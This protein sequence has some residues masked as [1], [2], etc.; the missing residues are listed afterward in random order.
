MAF[1]IAILAD[2]SREDG[3]ANGHLLPS[4]NICNHVR[5]VMLKNY[6]LCVPFP[7]ADAGWQF[8]GKEKA[9]NS[10]IWCYL[11]VSGEKVSGSNVWRLCVRVSLPLFATGRMQTLT[12]A[13]KFLHNAI[14]DDAR[15]QVL[16][17]LLYKEG[18]FDWG[19][20]DWKS[21]VSS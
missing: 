19:E 21:P 11:T 9:G 6:D 13:C 3:D 14:S 12:S 2:S 20:R 1:A 15:L 10:R 17:W 8:G 5:E 4:R 7:Y 18:W 16:K